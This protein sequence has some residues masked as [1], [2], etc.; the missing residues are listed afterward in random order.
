M[1]D[2]PAAEEGKAQPTKAHYDAL[3][4]AVTKTRAAIVDYI[5][6]DYANAHETIRKIHGIVSTDAVHDTLVS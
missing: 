6:S 4:S 3:L 5:M 2:T 1:S